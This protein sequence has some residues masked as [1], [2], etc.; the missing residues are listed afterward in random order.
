MIRL[1]PRATR[2][3]TPF[4]YTTLFR[5][6]PIDPKGRHSL[7]V[8]GGTIQTD[9][10]RIFA[11]ESYVDNVAKAGGIQD[12]PLNRSNIGVKYLWTVDDKSEFRVNRSEEHTSELQSLMRISYAVFCLKKKIKTLQHI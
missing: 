9:G 2:T 4:P 1:P 8:Y 10:P 5:A 7:M 6:F 11:P 3:D 12:Y